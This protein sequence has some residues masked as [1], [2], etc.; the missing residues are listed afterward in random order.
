MKKSNKKITRLPKATRQM[1]VQERFG[2]LQKLQELKWGYVSILCVVF[3]LALFVRIWKIEY[4]PYANDADELAYIWAG[5]SLIDFGAPISWSSFQHTDTQWHWTEIPNDTVEDTKVPI[6]QFV[7][8]W[9]DHSFVLPLLMGSW[10]VLLGYH[11]PSI[12]PALFYRLPFLLIAVLNLGLIYAIARQLFGK[13]PALFSLC[14]V[15]FSP[16]F[17]FAQRMVVSENLMATFFLLAVYLF[18]SGQSLFAILIASAFAGLV[19]LPGLSIVP[20]IAFAML[21]ERKFAK[22]A[23]YCVGVA[24]VVAVGYGLYGAQIDWVAFLSA[25]KDQSSRLLGWSNP[26]FLLSHPGF[27]TK[28]LLDMSYYVILFSGLTVFLSNVAKAKVVSAGIVITFLTIWVTS[29]EQD[30]LGWYKIPL[31]CLLAIG[32]AAVF[33]VLK[34]LRQRTNW[35]VLL[36]LFSMMIITNLGL[37]R[38]PAQPLPEAQLLRVAVGGLLFVSLCLIYFEVPRRLQQLL[39]VGLCCLYILQSFW[40]VDQFFAASCKDR[41]CPTPYVTLRQIVRST[42]HR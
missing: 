18:I 27:H 41:N 32:S 29:A 12:P 28:S 7:R 22:A 31:F 26:A 24:V 35:S 33:D 16:T 11:F 39:L 9:F 2:F 13:W 25:M 14:L 20:V 4:I 21:A 23:I 34:T 15:S 40:V 1:D 42:L 3:F 19:K 30:M 5:Q 37:I 10:S 36:M 38:Y 6:A 8:P 17:V